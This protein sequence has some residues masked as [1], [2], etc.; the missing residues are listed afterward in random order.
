MLNLSK[1]IFKALAVLGASLLLAMPSTSANAADEVFECDAIGDGQ[2]VVAI[3]SNNARQAWAYYQMGSTPVTATDGGIKMELTGNDRYEGAGIAFTYGINSGRITDFGADM[4]VGCRRNDRLA[5]P[6][7][8]TVAAKPAAQLTGQKGMA[9]GGNMR[10]G[11]GTKYGKI[12]SVNEGAALTILNNSGVRLDGYDWFEVQLNSGLKGF[13]WGGILCSEGQQL[14]GILYACAEWKASNQSFNQ[15][16]SGGW[17]AFA[18]GQN[19]RWGHGAA[20]TQYQARQFALNNCGS[21][22][23]IDHETQEKCQALATTPGTFWYGTANTASQAES[24]A[25]QFC[26]ATS[27]S[28]RIEYSY[29][30]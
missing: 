13:I 6:F 23:R 14:G 16:N 11:P 18:V 1:P 5:S 29:C 21:G 28:C 2:Y 4:E 26:S 22:C 12:A 27:G 17:M 30:R 10:S 24:F 15:Q 7:S 3:P 8:G 25:F 9:L 19:G 20:N